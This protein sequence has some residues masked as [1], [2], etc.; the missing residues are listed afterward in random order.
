MAEKYHGF[1]YLLSN[2]SMPNIYKIGFTTLSPYKRAEQLSKSTSCPTDFEVVCFAE[3]HNCYEAEKE[4]HRRFS[5]YRVN[6][7]KEFFKLSV[8]DL[9]TYVSYTLCAECESGCIDSFRTEVY[10]NYLN[11]FYKDVEF[12]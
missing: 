6:K 1:V 5:D 9:I 4:M 2:Q 12:V 11:L 7:G 10:E 8:E 3:F